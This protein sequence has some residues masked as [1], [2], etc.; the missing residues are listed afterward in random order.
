MGQPQRDEQRSPVAR[1]R[2]GAAV[3]VQALL[4]VPEVSLP[5]AELPTERP[6]VP[7]GQQAAPQQQA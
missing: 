2:D 3:S 6:A 5:R 1:L 4:L 7:D